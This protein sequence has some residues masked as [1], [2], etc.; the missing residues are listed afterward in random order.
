MIFESMIYESR[1]RM[2]ENPTTFLSGRVMMQH[3]LKNKKKTERE[4][5][6]EKGEK[7]RETKKKQRTSGS[8]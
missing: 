4:R 3:P 1:V 7:R 2:S 8:R 5:E 6:R